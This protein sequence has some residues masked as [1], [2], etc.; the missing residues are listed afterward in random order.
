MVG[1]RSY[2]GHVI[3][4]AIPGP[5]MLPGVMQNFWTRLASRYGTKKYWQ[6]KGEEAAIVNAVS[7]SDHN[8]AS[9]WCSF[10]GPFVSAPCA[11][12]RE[13]VQVCLMG[14]CSWVACFV[15][16][17]PPFT[18]VSAIDFCFREPAGRNQC[19]KIQGELGEEA[20]SG[21]SQ[22]LLQSSLCVTACIRLIHS[23]TH[24][25]LTGRPSLCLGEISFLLQA[26]WGRHFLAPEYPSALSC[27]CCLVVVIRGS[28]HDNFA[29]N[30]FSWPPEM[31]PLN[32][33]LC[34]SI[35]LCILLELDA[36]P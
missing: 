21:Q 9:V 36:L 3:R 15:L 7:L 23:S 5:D 12:A 14:D 27:S 24:T 8:D 18:Q 29:E 33:F 28:R 32:L 16:T 19:A 34:L 26:S 25:C 4:C 22:K 31:L 35:L 13:A 11:S 1:P 17:C 2:W 30:G 6:E 20:S 10:L